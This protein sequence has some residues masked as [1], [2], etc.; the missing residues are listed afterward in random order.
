MKKE[1][2]L[3]IL[4]VFF[5]ASAIKTT[6]GIIEKLGMQHNSAQY[7]IMGNF[8]GNFNGG[9][10]SE[11]D[12]F[13]I[14][15]AKMLPSIINGDK[16]GAAQELCLYIKQYANSEEFSETYKKK[17]EAA[18][19]ESEPWRPD[20]T[21]IDEQKKSV[22]DMEKQLADMKK[23][24]QMPAAT[25]QAME[26][27]VAD[28]K[29]MLA[30]WSDPTPN[31]TKWEKNFPE[32]PSVLIKRRLEKY[33]ALT[34]TVD[35]NAALTAADKYGKKKF[36]NP[37]YEKKSAEWKA[38]YRA[39]KDVNASVTA[40]V[41]EWLKG[42]IISNTKTSMKQFTSSNS[43]EANNSSTQSNSNTSKPSSSTSESTPEKKEKSS[44][45][46]KA[47]DKVKEKAKVIIN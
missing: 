38:A 13:Q 33:L 22:K 31:K 40:F 6:D 8:L 5:I 29:K 17:R 42:P 12:E 23:N 32:D 44:L 2:L 34:A 37:E 4:G 7:Y 36:T 46:N 25:I 1:L 9:A 41:K 47:K 3:P 35:F 21:M 27:A 15:Y 43:K 19:P 28:Q 20:Q 18:K 11:Y 16:T 26:K 10:E 14:P 24:K 30:E 45:L 39:G